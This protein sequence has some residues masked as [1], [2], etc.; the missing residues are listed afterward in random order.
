MFQSNFLKQKKEH[1]LSFQKVS[2][3]VQCL[4]SGSTG[5][6]EFPTFSLNDFCSQLEIRQQ[7]Y[8]EHAANAEQVKFSSE[9][10]QDDFLYMYAPAV[11]SGSCL[12]LCVF[13]SMQVVHN[14][15]H[16]GTQMPDSGIKKKMHKHFLLIRLIRVFG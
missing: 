10:L 11:R 15:C 14:M 4:C 7:L 9:I 13:I 16:C 3:Q 6:V 5:S 8:L 2:F 1:N 12:C